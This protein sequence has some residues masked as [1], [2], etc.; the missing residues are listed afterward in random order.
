M[1]DSPTS[2]GMV[3]ITTDGKILGI[4]E[5]DQTLS[6]YS[7]EKGIWG[8]EAFGTTSAK[9]F[10]RDAKFPS[11]KSKIKVIAEFPFKDYEDV[12]YNG[13]EIYGFDKE[14]NVYLGLVACNP[15][16]VIYRD[17]I[18]KCTQDGKVLKYL[19]VI[20]NPV[21]SPDIARH[22]LACPDGRILTFTS[23]E[24]EFYS[25]HYYDLR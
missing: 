20:D 21:L 19:D 17:R 7:S 13:G 15:V 5:C 11:D 24:V 9:L 8:I 12:K 18:Y 3:R 25:L 6:S 1:V 14:G 16:G 22:R 10:V 23:D 2:K 4:Y